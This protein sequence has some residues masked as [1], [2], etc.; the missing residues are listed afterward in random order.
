VKLTEFADD[1]IQLQVPKM[2]SGFD[3]QTQKYEPTTKLVEQYPDSLE[4]REASEEQIS[5]PRDQ[6]P[7]PRES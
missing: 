2:F 3:D 6:N 5:E 1:E 4:A 7:E